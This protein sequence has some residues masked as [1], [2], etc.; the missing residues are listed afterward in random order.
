[1]DN[2]DIADGGWSKSAKAWIA[3]QGKLGDHSRREILDPALVDIIGPVDGND[4]LDVGC[5]EGRYART[6]AALGANVTGLDIVDEFIARARNLHPDGIYF[7]GSAEELPFADQSFDLV[8]SYLS[9]IDV[10]D[11]KRAIT[12]MCRVT[13]RDG[14]IVFVTVSNF[15]V[16]ATG[17]ERDKQGRKLHRAVDDY[18]EER[19]LDLEW[20]GIRIR[21]FHRPMSAVLSEFFRSGALMDGFYEPLPAPDSPAYADEFRAPCFQIM[22]F[23]F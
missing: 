3:S 8:L 7:V 6:L 15:N 21:N 22:T 1:M 11:Y 12:E 16:T 18:M 19:I 5:G 2:F 10:P 20:N 4:I 17:W 13:K 23:R 9:L 14:R